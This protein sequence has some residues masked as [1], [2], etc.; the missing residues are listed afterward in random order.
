MNKK[1]SIIVPCYNQ[2]HFLPETLSSVL[3]Q[4]YEDWECIIVNDGSTD[5]TEAVGSEWCKKDV[6]FRYILL[7]NGERC[8]ARNTGIKES[9]GAYILPLDA[10]D[11]I[12]EDY[13]S[14]AVQAFS[15]N[16]EV[17]LV[18]A[19]AEYFGDLSGEWPLEDFDWNKFI[20]YNQIYV[21]ALFRRKDYDKTNGFNEQMKFGWEDWEFW[22]SLLK[23]NPKVYRIP[24]ICFYYRIRSQSTMQNMTYEQEKYSKRLIYLN[25]FEIYNHLFSDPITLYEDYRYGQNKIKLIES[26]ILFQVHRYVSFPLRYLKRNFFK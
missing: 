1:V 23:P 6:R 21:S 15:N 25:H 11:K 14:L 13:L 16:A 20:F 19:R 26:T 8:A 7:G 24:E 4:T 9:N 10:D 17:Q 2:G 18:Y 22:I 3:S 12:S 5:N